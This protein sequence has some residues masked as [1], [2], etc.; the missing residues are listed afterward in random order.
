MKANEKT[1]RRILL[2]EDND[3]VRTTLRGLL[4]GQGYE[5][6]SFPDPEVCPLHK[7]EHCACLADE[8]CADAVVTD[9]DMPH[10]TG[11]EFIAELKQ[12]GCKIKHVAMLS[13]T[14]DETV[15]SRALALGCQAFRK[16]EE[17]PAF[18]EWLAK[19]MAAIET[20]R[21]LKGWNAAD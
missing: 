8:A 10:V 2:F 18:L 9:Q 5:V 7:A 14:P 19:A 1:K 16:P 15:R 21:H 3:L 17:I 12:K 13:G 11:L 6:F 4:A 20:E